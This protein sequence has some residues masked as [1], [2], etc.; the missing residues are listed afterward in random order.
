LATLRVC[1][2][3]VPGKVNCGICEK[4]L[5]TRLE[6]LAAGVEETEALGPS[7]T[8]IELWEAAVPV[9]IGHRALRY[10]DLLPFLRAR[11]HIELCEVL[12]AKI[13]VYRQRVRDG[14]GWPGL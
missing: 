9:P 13:A 1:P 4:C 3:N 2:A 6:L 8:P 11:G 5:G 14:V 10:E 7:L 12:Q